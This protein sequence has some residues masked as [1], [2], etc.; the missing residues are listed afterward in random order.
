MQQPGVCPWACVPHRPRRVHACLPRSKA[1]RLTACTARHCT[2][3]HAAV[4][5]LTMHHAPPAQPPCN[6]TSPHL[7]A[8]LCSLL[9]SAA[10]VPLKG[11]LVCVHACAVQVV[12]PGG[13]MAHAPCTSWSEPQAASGGSEDYPAGTT[14]LVYDDRWAHWLHV[15]VHVHARA[16]PPC[17]LP[18][19]PAPHC[20]RAWGAWRWRAYARCSCSPAWVWVLGALHP[21][22]TQHP[23]TAR[24]L[25]AC[26]HACVASTC[27][28]PAVLLTLTA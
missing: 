9:C 22:V 18:P 16:S 26:M 14:L 19:A 4:W 11:L 25:H 1:T 2:A 17:P 21:S 28:L 10:H 27:L 5:R 3:R 6:L 8:L 12:R 15:R 23:Q 20:D 24:Q 7:H 13:P